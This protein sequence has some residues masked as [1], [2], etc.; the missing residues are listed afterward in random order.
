MSDQVRLHAKVKGRVQ[1]VS[2][3]YYTMLRAYELKVVGWVQNLGDGSVEVI[4][5]GSQSQLDDLL[6][7]LH[8]GPSAARVTSV[9]FEWQ[10]GTGEFTD[11]QVR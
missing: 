9:N 1:G 10:P 3:R 5:E 11:F 2:F 6:A 4:A 8:R 7:Y